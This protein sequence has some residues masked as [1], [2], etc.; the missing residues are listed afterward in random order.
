MTRR[1]VRT[2]RISARPPTP[3]GEGE[4]RAQRGYVPQYR[5][6][7]A[8]IYDHIASGRLRWIGVAHRGAGAFDDIVV[9]LDDAIVGHQVKTSLTPTPFQLEPLLLGAEGLWAVILDSLERLTGLGSDRLASVVYACDDTPSLND[10]LAGVPGA[11]SRGLL[12][13]HRQHRDVW[14]WPHWEATAYAPFLRSLQAAAALED[15]AF[16]AA[17]RSVTF[18]TGGLGR[19][20][21]SS[22]RTRQD[23]ARIERLA[24][25]LPQLAA[26]P[27]N[28][29]EWTLN[30]VRDRLGWRDA[31]APRHSHLFPLPDV[32]EENETARAV[33]STALSTHFRGYL[34]L[35]GPPGS[36]K[37]TLLAAG[38]LDAEKMRT[39]RYLAFVPGEGQSLGRAEAFDFLHDLVAGFK[40]QG[41][42]PT[43]TPG[44]TLP[45]LREQLQ[46]LLAEAGRRFA[47]DGVRTLIIVDGLDHVPR[48][49]RY[50]QSLL[51]AL[52]AP[53]ALPEGV[54]VLLGTQR[55]DLS[56]IPPA[57]QRQAAEAGR[58]ITIPPL[59]R[60][61]VHRL[62]AAVGLAGDPDAEALFERGQGHPLSTRYLLQALATQPDPEDR[63]A[64]LAAAP[65]Y[66]GDVE[67]FYASAWDALRDAT[68]ARKALSYIALADGP[69]RQ[70]ALDGLVGEV[71]VDAAWRAAR[72][73]L[74]V[75]PD[76]S[77]S[78]FHNS[79][80][81]YLQARTT[82][83]LDRPDATLKRQRFRDLAGMASMTTP[84]DPQR[85]MAL[86][87]RARAEDHEEVLALATA[88]RFRSEFID[89]RDPQ[90]T[91]D[92]IGLAFRSV[93]VRRRAEALLPLILA[94]HELALRSEAIN[95]DIVAA[96]LAL[97]DRD[98]ARAALKADGPTLSYDVRYRVVDEDLR[99]GDKSQARAAF[100][101]LEPLDQILGAE[102]VSSTSWTDELPD[103]A[104]RVLAF[105]PVP[106]F[107]RA[108]DRLIAPV[109]DLRPVDLKEMR[110]TLKV[111][112]MEGELRRDP[113]RDPDA[114]RIALNL[115][116]TDRAAA[117]FYGA[118]SSRAHGRLEA[119][120]ERAEAALCAVNDLEDHE[121]LHLAMLARTI[122][123]P[124]LAG[125]A[126]NGLDAPSLQAS[127][128]RDAD[129]LAQK[130]AAVVDFAETRAALGLPL[131][132]GPA[133]E[134]PYLVALQQRLEDLGDT[135]G[136][137]ATGLAEPKAAL[138]SLRSALTF[139]A[140]HSNG[141]PHDI[142]RYRLDQAM[143]GLAGK[144]VAGAGALGPAALQT[145]LFDAD[146]PPEALWRLRQSSVRRAIGV[147]AFRCDGDLDAAR[148]RVAYQAGGER[149]P[150]AE[151]AEAAASAKALAG[152]GLADEARALLR[153]MHAEGLGLSRP[154]KKDPQYFAWTELLEEACKADPD[155]R[156]DRV[157]FMVRFASGLS[158]NEGYDI[159]GR[160][161]P[162]ILIEAAQGRAALALAAFDTAQD[163]GD[164]AWSRLIA[165]AGLGIARARPD[166]T[167]EAATIVGRL[168]T[169]YTDEHD[170]DPLA[171]LVAAAPDEILSSVV[172]RLL[173]VV[174]TESADAVRLKLLERVIDDARDRELVTGGDRLARWKSELPLPSSGSSPE[175]PYFHTR[176][177]ADIGALLDDPATEN[178]WN[179]SRAFERIGPREGYDAALRFLDEHPG[180]RDHRRV[181]RIMADMALEAGRRIDA[182]AFGAAL[183][184][185]AESAGY[186]DGWAGGSRLLAAQVDAVIRGE[187]GRRAAFDALLA[188]LTAGRAWPSRLL[189]YIVDILKVVS[190]TPTWSDA[191]R[192]LEAHLGLFREFAQ[193]AALAVP[194]APA[195]QNDGETAL[196]DLLF[197]A[198]QLGPLVLADR[199]RLAALEI[200][201][202]PQGRQIIAAL[203]QRLLES[204]DDGPLRGI[205]IAWTHRDHNETR[206]ALVGRLDELAKHPDL[207]VRCMASALGTHWRMPTPAPSQPASSIPAPAPNPDPLPDAAAAFIDDL[208][209]VAKH[210]T[211]TA[212]ATG[213]P[214]TALSTRAAI[215]MSSL[216]VPPTPEAEQKAGAKAEQ[217]DARGPQVRLS[218]R[219]AFLAQRRLLSE[220]HDSGRLDAKDA[221]AIARRSGVDGRID[222]DRKIE[223][224]PP[225]TV[226]PAF[227]DSYHDD[228]DAVWL[229]EIE[230]DL[231]LPRIDGWVV[232]A[233]W[234]RHQRQSRGLEQ[235]AE[236]IFG[237]QEPGDDFTDTMRALASI[238]LADIISAPPAPDAEPMLRRLTGPRFWYRDWSIGLCP[239]LAVHL[240][241]RSDPR[242]PVRYLDSAGR[243][244]VRTLDWRDSATVGRHYGEAVLRDGQLVIATSLAA[245][246]LDELLVRPLE[247]HAWRKIVRQGSTTDA[248]AST[249]LSGELSRPQ[250]PS[251]PDA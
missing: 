217:L 202:R 105:R 178:I 141:D 210:L 236:Q 240:G 176:S 226:R 11:T 246:A 5:L 208:W 129:D 116:T 221:E 148:T 175:N 17:W 113:D 169:L 6:G 182:G 95:E 54:T 45:E 25:V 157:R 242:D 195:A 144:I 15:A 191:W 160:I 13:L 183:Q 128:L 56:D 49:E 115:P 63:K 96:W 27:A 230:T 18:Q 81:L 39:L 164:L 111:R 145:L 134:R 91:H 50:E 10:T 251:L 186:D 124:D 36:G 198:L 215:I 118:R 30:E 170:G 179:A 147:Q 204:A 154:A 120:A 143:A 35:V 205:Q 153:T 77:L 146:N 70:A 92:D 76:G 233:G 241:W 243:L 161:L 28:R 23:A 130:S 192:A 79:F 123:R 101:A 132:R 83:R 24:G 40:A 171:G 133:P 94:R 20:P 47:R 234:A 67:T 174:E 58:Q 22:E 249:T 41:L 142:D 223:P 84:D 42:G 86:R 75:G 4:R 57:V 137:V 189:Q 211:A 235:R 66:A 131:L 159:G 237:I 104:G 29:D 177:F 117:W 43:I 197:R 250:R 89:G 34:A 68:D 122:A 8:L 239:D 55:I 244:Q 71:A 32:Y 102:A 168:A 93:G 100:E 196:A 238:S 127:N 31:F 98:A 194:D 158:E 87:Y 82:E 80:R 201:E 181:L 224:R 229:A 150:E 167:L 156:E 203:T 64:W 220:L 12:D 14:D 248:F 16:I 59:T 90:D 74:A 200:S 225:A 232:L 60:E 2:P 38:V 99:A 151:L 7:A 247:V 231:S 126:L 46:S 139:L 61:A 136:A 53:D 188:D 62:A 199:V 212:R 73:L 216:A 119:A 184:T 140:S 88:D 19:L 110:W 97:G 109:D 138:A 125:T 78:L 155:G 222:L 9:C 135:L 72:H 245:E 3:P 207:G 163:L 21:L 213:E 209:P 51:T 48:E 180:L 218:G 190:P 185:L 114:L 172:E 162:A 193:G 106:Q 107:L 227:T 33:I 187:A 165:A 37:S 65:A 214:L 1:P 121:R 52:P 103:W 152:L 219:G 149:T 112:A 26:D 166:L 85:W 44:Q 228:H 173:D 206:A 108:L 69:L